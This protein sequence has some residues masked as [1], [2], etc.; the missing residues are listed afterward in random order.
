MVDRIKGIGDFILELVQT[1]QGTFTLGFLVAGILGGLTS[2]L[3]YDQMNDYKDSNAIYKTELLDCQKNST[4]IEMNAQKGCIE[5][6]QKQIEAIMRVS[7]V[8]KSQSETQKTYIEQRKIRMKE[9]KKFIKEIEKVTN[10]N[11]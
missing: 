3:L 10:E 7:E 5:N 6:A 4:T 8:L 2:F 9:N 1:K 11:A